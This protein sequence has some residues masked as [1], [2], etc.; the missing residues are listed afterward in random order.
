MQFYVIIV[1]HRW[2]VGEIN[3]LFAIIIDKH[4]VV[5][6]INIFLLL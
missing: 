6:E 3:V 1:D 4:Q 2:M 5:R